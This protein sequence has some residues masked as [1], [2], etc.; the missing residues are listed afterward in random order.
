MPIDPS[1]A[2]QFRLPQ[3]APPQMA[4][5]LEQFGKMLPLRE[6]MQRGQL[7]ALQLQ[8]QQM[9]IQEQRNL[10][11]LFSNI[12]GGTQPAPAPVPETPGAAAVPTQ[13]EI[14][15]PPVG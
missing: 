10:A 5:P 14:A 13:P 3:I 2:L 8:Q 11:N 4:T 1:I 12:Y 7:G 9:A 15:G 6:L